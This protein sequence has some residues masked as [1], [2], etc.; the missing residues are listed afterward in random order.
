MVDDMI[1]CMV[2]KSMSGEKHALVL[3]AGEGGNVWKVTLC[4]D[5]ILLLCGSMLYAVSL[6]YKMY[7]ALAPV[8]ATADTSPTVVGAS[9]P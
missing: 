1:S 4:H 8:Q 2:V 6:L 9:S 7:A 5:V 3:A